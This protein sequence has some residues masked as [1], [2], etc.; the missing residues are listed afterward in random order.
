MSSGN[1]IG[2]SPVLL[3]AIS[4]SLSSVGASS[5]TVTATNM[6]ADTNCKGA[7]SSDDIVAQIM[8]QQQD[9]LTLGQSGLT[10]PTTIN[11]TIKTML[12]LKMASNALLKDTDI[13][14]VKESTLASDLAMAN[15][16]T[17]LASQSRE[18]TQP[19]DTGQVIVISN[20]ESPKTV[21]PSLGSEGNVH[22][23]VLTDDSNSTLKN[24]PRSAQQS[25]Q[26][27]VNVPLSPS[28]NYTLIKSEPSSSDS[29]NRLIS[30]LVTHQMNIIASESTS[31]NGQSSPEISLSVPE[32]TEKGKLS[33][34]NPVVQVSGDIESQLML[35]NQQNSSTLSG[36]VN[37]QSVGQS[38]V[39]I[40]E[41]NG[42]RYIIQMQDIETTAS[43]S[44]NTEEDSGGKDFSDMRD[45]V[46]H[47][48]EGLPLA[49]MEQEV[50]TV[51]QQQDVMMSGPGAG[52]V[53]RGQLCPICGDSVSGFHYGIF[54]CESCKGFFKRTVQN[55]KT[56]VCPRQGECE[57]TLENR[58]KCPACRF[59]KCL[60]MGMK[61]EAIRMDRTRGG[62]SSYSG[63]SPSEEPK[64]KRPIKIV[65]NRRPSSQSGE[66]T[67]SP[68][69]R[70]GP[71]QC[72]IELRVIPGV[73]TDI[74]SLESILNEDDIPANI[75][76][77]DFS[78]SNPSVFM[79]LLQLCELKL[80]K[81]VRWARNLPYFANVSTD[82][83]ILLLQNCW[84]ELL[85]LT[86]C[87]KSLNLKE[88]I[89]FFHGQ[90]IDQDKADMLNVREMFTKMLLVVEQFKRIN[91]DQYE[92]VAMKVI[93]LICPDIKGLS[94]AN[95][96]AVHQQ[97]ISVALEDYVRSHYRSTP[98]RYGEILLRLP[99]LSRISGL[100]KEHL[101]QWM[102]ANT[103]SCGLLY[104]LLKGENMKDML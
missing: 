43:N 101:I 87:W 51:T 54:T 46:I 81:I 104:E 61:L 8:K 56:F 20:Q 78:L 93:I 48:S 57:I 16:L 39:R 74:M 1:E 38:S 10:P 6:A 53:F 88:E 55:K 30:P 99:E 72:E 90:P 100:M 24:P 2:I 62:R 70:S 28:Y 65:P 86:M 42:K 32:V 27:V 98:N 83:Q 59:A 96:L 71:N 19:V 77:D 45:E 60:I 102:P 40:F 52:M 94:D 64:R 95:S 36:S 85:A 76:V 34:V 11:D 3:Q 22:T 82:D 26:K 44:S 73:L 68:L 91:V 18:S 63:S 49:G 21:Q 4:Q 75:S 89:V 14:S 37:A 5:P 13:T 58:K 9:Q 79:T 12:R 29:E 35:L 50:L 41:H 92:C 15:M 31:S 80:Y 97:N 25:V 66:A 103:T 23:V 47:F 17:A 69:M 7:A 33:G 84:C 67:Q